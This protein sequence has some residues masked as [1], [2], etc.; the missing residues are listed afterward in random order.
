MTCNEM[1]SWSTASSDVDENIYLES[2]KESQSWWIF[3]NI[4]KIHEMIWNISRF[5]LRWRVVSQTNDLIWLRIGK[6][7][8]SQDSDQFFFQHNAQK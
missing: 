5:D 8:F 3:Q 6:K 2:P 1:R 7:M 4:V